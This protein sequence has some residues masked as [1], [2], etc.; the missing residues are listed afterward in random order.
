MP[1]DTSTDFQDFWVLWGGILMKDVRQI[2]NQ[3]FFLNELWNY[4]T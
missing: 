4:K 2:L 1:C 3:F